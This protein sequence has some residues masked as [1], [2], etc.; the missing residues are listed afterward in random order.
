MLPFGINLPGCNDCLTTAPF[1]FTVTFNPSSSRRKTASLT[2]IP[3]TSGIDP[4]GMISGT[5]IILVLSSEGR[6]HW[7][8]VLIGFTGKFLVFVAAMG[9]GYF[10]LVLIAM[11]NVVVSLYYY[12][13]VIKAAYLLEP[14][15]AS[16]PLRVSP[17]IQL[18]AGVL[19]A[20]MIVA[21]LF[22]YYLVELAEAAAR[23]LR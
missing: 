3:V 16:P 23:G 1:P 20:V 2:L 8:A 17:S 22:P 15:Q 13:L 6:T 10:T 19:I 11:I 7:A 4:L 12:L 18:L 14:A 9:K 5:R 21:G